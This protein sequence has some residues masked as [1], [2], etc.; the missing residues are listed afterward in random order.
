MRVAGPRAPDSVTSMSGWSLL[1]AQ[2]DS[3]T[4]G[5]S[6]SESTRG[7]V[8]YRRGS[9]GRWPT[10]PATPGPTAAASPT[11]AVRPARAPAASRVRS[12]IR[13]DRVR[14]GGGPVGCGRAD[15]A[16]ATAQL[17][18][19][20]SGCHSPSRAV[21]PTRYSAAA[22]TVTT[23]AYPSRTRRYRRASSAAASPASHTATT[24]TAT[25]SGSGSTGRV[26]VSSR[27]MPLRSASAASAGT[28]PGTPPS[29]ARYPASA[30]TDSGAAVHAG[31]RRAASP[32]ATE[33]TAAA[34]NSRAASSP[35]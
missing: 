8:T 12:V 15:A 21:G 23:G 31:R 3:R 16:S 30:R 17:P 4:S 25:V 24:G 5:S 28:G 29:R 33:A 7:G 32:T 20:A 18:A 13:W 10:R 6:S 14:P 11:T 1:S 27:G 35:R 9:V 34:A 26:A 19:T 2:P 22:Y